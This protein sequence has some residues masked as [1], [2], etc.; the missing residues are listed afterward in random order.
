LDKRVA[1]SVGIESRLDMFDDGDALSDL[2]GHL[3]DDNEILVDD[4][5]S[6][7]EMAISNCK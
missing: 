7:N 6:E 4:F 1:K 2:E 3:P 5:T